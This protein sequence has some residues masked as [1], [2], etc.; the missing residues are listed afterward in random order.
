M[1][2]LATIVLILTALAARAEEVFPLPGWKDAPN[3][4]A[5]RDAVVG[6]EMS[7]FAHQYPKSFNYLLDNNAFSAELF[8]AMY[9]SL[10]GLHP[11]T[12]EFEP[13]LAAKWA[14]SDD[15]TSFTFWIDDRARWSDGRPVT[16]YDAR[17]TFDAIM[18]TNNITGVHKVRL[19]KFLPPQVIDER[20]IRFTATEVH[21]RNLG[22]A[23]IFPVMPRHCFEG[24]DFNK[25]NFEFP[26]ISGPYRLGEIKEGVF[27]KLERRGD[28]WGRDL[29]RNRNLGNFETLTFR[30]F[31]ESENAFEA[32]KKGRIDLF[33]VYTAR[34][35]VNET[36]S[37][38]FAKHWIARQKVYNRHPLGFQGFA[39][40][41]RRPP[42][43]DLKVRRAMA[44]LLD[45]EKM[46]H[47]IMYSQYYLHRSYYEDLY[48][49]AD[50]CP[51]PLYRFDKAAARRLLQEAG[52][53][54]NPQSGLLEKG[55]QP[56]RI[57]FLTRSPGSEKFLAIF[58][59]DLRD[60][61]I[62]LTIDQKDW[63]AWSEDMRQFNF[64]MTWAAWGAALRKDPEGMWASK[65]AGRAGGTT[66]PASRTRGWT[67]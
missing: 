40:N 61:G 7:V 49:A 26:V 54:A 23:G 25:I 53:S 22:A 50:P 19:E 27:V 9:E 56:F 15:R 12:A 4:L 20:T 35:W 46:N 34:L 28:W 60:V 18:D 21:W 67:R 38:R 24:R 30:F 10:L 47:T 44:H 11:L 36:R 55:G 37:E 13:N 43:N 32:F 66:S 17:W 16:A 14:I 6:G 52:W 2:R 42:F 29:A 31:A 63:A 45:R 39:M 59:E 3:P 41:M 64:S 62:E 5:G 8:D 48:S 57:E 1:K 65:E 58:R 33:P 51:N